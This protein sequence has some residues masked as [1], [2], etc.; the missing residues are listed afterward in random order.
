MSTLEPP[1][2]NTKRSGSIIV[3]VGLLLFAAALSITLVTYSNAAHAAEGGT[4]VVAWGPGV[5]GV[6]LLLVGLSRLRRGT[7]AVQAQW[8]H[9]PTGRHEYRYWDGTAWTDQ[10]TDAKQQTT[11]PV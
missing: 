4:Y 5:L 6:V 1:G 7:T 10:V 11:D 2:A 8:H 9:D 3:L